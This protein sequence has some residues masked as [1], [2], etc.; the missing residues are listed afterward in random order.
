MAETSIRRRLSQQCGADIILL[1]ID[2]LLILFV[3]NV[4]DSLVFNIEI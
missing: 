1:V 4:K 3:T 2:S